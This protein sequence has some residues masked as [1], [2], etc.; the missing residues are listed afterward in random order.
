MVIFKLFSLNRVVVYNIIATAGESCCVV[1]HNN[2]GELPL[3]KTIAIAAAVIMACVNI[4]LCEK[5]YHHAVFSGFPTLYYPA[6]SF[7]TPTPPL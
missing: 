7:N 5:T 6:L 1:H 2:S 4:V 3:I